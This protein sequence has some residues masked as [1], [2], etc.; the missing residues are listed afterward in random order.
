MALRIYHNV[1]AMTA[2]RYLAVNT[3]E[4]NKS[5]ERLSSGLRINRAADDAA[6]LAISQ[7]M[8]AQIA[9]MQQANRNAA[10]AISLIQTAE[11]A[12]NTVHDILTRIRELVVQAADESITS[13]NRT[14][15]KDEVTALI[16]EIERIA[17]STEFNDIAI[18]SENSTTF[19]FQIGPD[20]S[21]DDRLD[22]TIKGLHSNNLGPANNGLASV[23]LDSATS[24]Q[25]SITYVDNAIASLSSF[26]ADLGAAQ[27]RLQYIQ[28]DLSTAIEN[29]QSAES[30]IRDVDVAA[31]TARLTRYQILQQAA[32]AMLAQANVTPQLALQLLGG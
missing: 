13:D 14:E 9:G 22:V 19:T 21:S 28:N 23:D 4:L 12:M 20:N 8:R 15:I 17:D 27:N 2:Q 25:T 10:N 29:L 3:L 31:E 6:G 11:G 32:A 26:R 18:V 5:L 30:V 24:A 7:S 1:A 16:N